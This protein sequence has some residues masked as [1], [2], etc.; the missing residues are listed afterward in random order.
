M[1]STSE[2]TLATMCNIRPEWR[3]NAWKHRNFIVTTENE[4]KSRTKIVANRTKR[5]DFRED[6]AVLTTE[7]TLEDVR[8]VK[9]VAVQLLPKTSRELGG[10]IGTIL[11]AF[12]KDDKTALSQRTPESGRVSRRKLTP[13]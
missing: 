2:V 5:T 12:R 3:Q 10:G 8:I 4:R 1:I 7:I 9:I 11:P 13:F 6:I